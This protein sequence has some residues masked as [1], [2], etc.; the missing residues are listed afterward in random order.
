MPL[1]IYLIT[2]KGVRRCSA[3][4][5]PFS[6]DSMPKVTQAFRSHVEEVH[7]TADPAG[8]EQ[9]WTAKPN[10]SQAT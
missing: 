7:R 8:V 5:E 9:N 10:A 4:G 2:V 1:P 6:D 3:C